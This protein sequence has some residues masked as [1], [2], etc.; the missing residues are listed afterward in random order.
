MHEAQGADQDGGL[1][2]QGP[3]PRTHRAARLDL[4]AAKPVVI[5]VKAD[6]ETDLE[7]LERVEPP[8]PPRSQRVLMS[9]IDIAMI[10][11]P[12]VGADRV[13]YKDLVMYSP[14]LSGVVEAAAA[15]QTGKV[16]AV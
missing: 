2:P 8:P 5:D 15:A 9:A 10:A 12:T 6:N 16:V 14:E 11:E 7:S 1:G 3:R 13:L 4:E